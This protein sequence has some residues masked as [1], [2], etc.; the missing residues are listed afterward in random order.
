M[1]S[2][3]HNFSRQTVLFLVA[4]LLIAIGFV[5]LI[6]VKPTLK[7]K[8]VVSSPIPSPIVPSYPTTSGKPPQFI[9]LSF[10]GS[11]SLEMWQ[12]SRKFAQKMKEEGKPLHFTYFISGVYFLTPENASTYLAPR[13]VPGTSDIGFADSKEDIIER[14]KQMNGAI[15]EGHEIGSHANGHFAGGVWTPDEWKQEFNEFNK[16]VFDWKKNNQ[17]ENAENIEELHL[18]PKEVIGFR[19]PLLSYNDALFKELPEMNFKYDSSTL[20]A[21]PSAWPI[22]NEQ[23]TW[24]IPLDQIPLAG[25]KGQTIAMDYNFYM[26]Q[27]RARDIARRGTPTWQRFYKQMYDSYLND[28][29]RHYEGTRSPVIIGHHFST[30][31][32][33]VYWQAM[34]D[35]AEEVCGKPEVYCVNFKDLVEYLDTHPTRE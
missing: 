19:A 17:L 24:L 3:L 18:Q 16:L 10:D 26:S 8:N 29:Q 33:G 5:G 1:S 20:V 2:S 35:F 4:G 6:K 30:W 11:R 13:R 21:S 31:N 15:S 32:D 9:V 34:Q 28:F 12:S 7:S 25:T 14:I 23:G 22:K 27:S